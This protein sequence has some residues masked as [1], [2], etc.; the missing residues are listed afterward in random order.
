MRLK[1]SEKL[2]KR[3]FS[4]WRFIIY[5]FS[6]LIKRDPNLWTF[7]TFNKGFS[8]NAKYL[9]LYITEH[10]P[11]INAVWICRAQDNIPFLKSKGI[12]AYYKYSSKA[13]FLMLKAKVHVCN[14]NLEDTMFWLSG[15][16]LYVNLWHGLPLKKIEFDIK[17]GTNA[18]KYNSHSRFGHILKTIAFP[19]LYRKPNLLPVC[20]E[21]T[22]INLRSAFRLSE[23]DVV[24]SVFPRNHIFTYQKSELKKLVQ[25]YENAYTLELLESLE[26][27]NKIYI[28][29]PTF[30]DG[31]KDFISDSRLDFNELNQALKM[32]NDILLVK[33]HPNIKTFC[34][35]LSNIAFMDSKTDIYPFL[36]FTDCLI[37]DYSSVYIDYLLLDKPIIFYCYDKERYI[38]STRG[39]YY[40]YD[41]VTPGIKC[42][43]FSELIEYISLHETPD[44]YKSE[45]LA[46]KNLFWD[47]TYQKDL[48][49]LVISIKER[50][51]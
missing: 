10:F 3:L 34:T 43:N 37:S 36:P 27:Y 2:V 38:N 48:D 25:K 9:Y 51:Q 15:N 13:F 16:A 6:M 22:S 23:Q 12:N 47:K 5:L 11:E 49:Q 29:L 26:D 21:S 1:H 19:S 7:G 41:E 17:K 31:I 39:L 4:S 32:N 40:N 44:K 8:D 18:W 30:R 28:Y 35:N 45:R 46:I 20:S 42:N 24:Y 14:T 50:L 33:L